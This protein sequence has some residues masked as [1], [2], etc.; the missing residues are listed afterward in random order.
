[1]RVR[2]EPGTGQRSLILTP[3]KYRKSGVRP[4]GMG[5]LQ[6]AS[7]KS[8]K[9]RSN[10]KET[11]HTTHNSH[12]MS[13]VA[14]SVH[15]CLHWCSHRH[16]ASVL[17]PCIYP[18]TLHRCSHL[19]GFHCSSLLC[20][21]LLAIHI[22]ANGGDVLPCMRIWIPRGRDEVYIRSFQHHAGQSWRQQSEPQRN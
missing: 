13:S 20:R 7:T 21:F 10:K 15:C 18:A 1:M 3:N 8:S 11:A 5:E 17:A 6:G 19:A 2:L 16:L 14:I 4:S 12:F 22:V 9:D